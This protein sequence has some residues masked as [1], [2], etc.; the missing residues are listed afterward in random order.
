[1]LCWLVQD[2]HQ[3]QGGGP[4]SQDAEC[5][6]QNAFGKA[7]LQPGSQIAPIRPP[8]PALKPTIQCGAMWSAAVMAA[9]AR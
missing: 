3:V 6:A 5:G 4:D 8:A 2:L 1:M 9:K 7:R